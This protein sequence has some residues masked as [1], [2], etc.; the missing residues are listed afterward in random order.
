MN[1]VGRVLIVIGAVMIITVA[2]IVIGNRAHPARPTD[3]VPA[4]TVATMVTVP[5]CEDNGG[6]VPCYTLDEGPDGCGHWI[7][8][9]G[10]DPLTA[11]TVDDMV[12]GA[13]DALPYD[14][15]DGCRLTLG[16]HP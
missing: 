2:V 11:W 16:R 15:R 1:R 10:R 14:G 9:L 4:P 12:L 5:D 8:V 7:I 6:A 13:R 3:P